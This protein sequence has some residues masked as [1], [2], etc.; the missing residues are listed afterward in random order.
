[1]RVNFCLWVFV[2][3]SFAL[4]LWK[5]ARE[6]AF[7]ERASGAGRA[8]ERS[9]RVNLCP[10]FGMVT[11]DELYVYYRLMCVKNS[12]LFICCQCLMSE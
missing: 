4:V 8:I 10:C 1:M 3:L 2:L 5:P 6:R 9:E 11:S 12:C 7:C